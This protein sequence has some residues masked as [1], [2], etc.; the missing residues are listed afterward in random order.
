MGLLNLTCWAAWLA[1]LAT[2]GTALPELEGFP[3]YIS[4]TDLRPSGIPG[5]PLLVNSVVPAC[6]LTSIRRP[7]VR[8]SM[9]SAPATD[10]FLHG[11]VGKLSGIMKALGGY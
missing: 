5:E 10:I 9:E 1:F 7:R 8:E 6:L 3:L 2:T 4:Y 11:S